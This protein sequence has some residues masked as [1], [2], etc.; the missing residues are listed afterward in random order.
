MQKRILTYMIAFAAII[1]SII[2]IL[3]T[4]FLDDIYKNIK[5]SQIRNDSETIARLALV[6]GFEESVYELATRQNTCITVFVIENGV[7]KA[8]VT[9]HI[10]N[11]CLIHSA[12][13]DGLIN[14]VYAG[15]LEHGTYTKL[16]PAENRNFAD[17][18]LCAQ[19]AEGS[20]GEELLILLNTE[21]QPVNATVT[22]LRYLLLWITVVIAIVAV[23]ISYLISQTITKPVAKMN[24]EAKK[25][26]L[27][28]Y[29][30]DFDGGGYLETAELANT[31]NYAT[32]ELSKLDTMQKELIANISHDLRTPLT[33]ISGYS[34]VMRDIPGEMTAENMQIIIDET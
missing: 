17:T 29:D 16:L 14:S 23:V 8:H 26:A 25:L 33:M 22:T 18:I 7:G 10:Q 30:V 3:Q 13:S 32:D 9:A 28:N 12:F 27:G 21:I 15:A 20:S 1:L 11:H 4:V 24:E 31:L 2:W 19:I 34:E 6:D 5:E